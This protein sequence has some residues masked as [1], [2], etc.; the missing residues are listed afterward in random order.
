VCSK[1]EQNIRKTSEGQQIFDCVRKKYVALTPEEL[2]RQN[3]ITYLANI[4]NYPINLMR[5]EAG[6][7][8]NKMQKRCDILIYNRNRN[9]LLMVECKAK[10]VKISQD[11]FNQLARYNLVFKVPYLVA[12]NGKDTYCCKINFEM[13]SYEYLNEIPAFETISNL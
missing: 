9:P 6:I 7:K 8:L 13:Q 12:T 1:A 10:N 5:V 4:K 3:I 11:I 2:V